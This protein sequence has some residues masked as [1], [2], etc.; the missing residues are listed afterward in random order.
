M[1]FTIA[2]P[3]HGTEHPFFECPNSLAKLVG[4]VP[5]VPCEAHGDTHPAYFC[6]KGETVAA[7]LETLAHVLGSE[8]LE[9]WLSTP[10]VVLLGRTPQSLLDG[11]HADVFLKLAADMCILGDSIAN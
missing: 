4:S 11:D 5:L 8:K 6:P 10:D 3:K 7:A 2:C 1:L 9:T